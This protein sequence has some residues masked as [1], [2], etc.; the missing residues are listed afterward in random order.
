[1]NISTPSIDLRVPT[2]DDRG[3]FAVDIDRLLVTSEPD[4]WFRKD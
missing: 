2:I 1:M 3:L 4:A